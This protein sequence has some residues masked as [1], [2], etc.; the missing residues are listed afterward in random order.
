VA[1]HI[2]HRLG[3]GQFVFEADDA[4]GGAQADAAVNESPDA[5]RAAVAAVSAAG[6][7]HLEMA[8]GSTARRNAGVTPTTSAAAPIA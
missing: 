4:Y 2:D 7:G 3:G 6:A 1:Q 8:G 5:L